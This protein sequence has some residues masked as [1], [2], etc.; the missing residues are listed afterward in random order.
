MHPRRPHHIIKCYPWTTAKLKAAAGAHLFLAEKNDYD[1][2]GFLHLE[3]YSKML[4]VGEWQGMNSTK[5]KQLPGAIPNAFILLGGPN[6]F[7]CEFP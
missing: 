1:I 6:R 5:M 7:I 4:L 2:Q 3:W